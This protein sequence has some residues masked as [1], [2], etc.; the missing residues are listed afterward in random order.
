MQTADAQ[1]EIFTGKGDGTFVTTSTK[2]VFSTTYQA[3][4]VAVGD[5]NG[6]GLPDIAVSSPAQRVAGDPTEVWTALSLTPVTYF[7]NSGL[8]GVTIADF[9]ND[10]KMDILVNEPSTTD[11]S[12]QVDILLGHGDGTFANSVGYPSTSAAT[13]AIVGDFNHDGILDYAV[14]NNSVQGLF[15]TSL[16]S[17]FLGTGDGTFTNSVAQT[18]SIASIDYPQ[19]IAAADFSGSGLLGVA[20]VGLD[21]NVSVNLGYQV[22]SG[23]LPNITVIQ[24]D[25]VTGTYIPGTGDAYAGSTS[26]PLTLEPPS[27]YFS[28]AFDGNAT[29]LDYTTGDTPAPLT[30]IVEQNQERSTTAAFPITLTVQGPTGANAVYHQT[31]VAGSTTFSLPVLT[32]AGTYKVTAHSA[33]AG[34]DATLNLVVAAGAQTAT[35]LFITSP[36][37]SHASKGIA[38]PVTLSVLG[39][40][41]H[42]ADLVHGDCDADDDR[43]RG[44][45]ESCELYVC[46]GGQ[47]RRDLPR[48]VQH[49]GHAGPYI[50]EHGADGG[51]AGGHPCAAAVGD[52]EFLVDTGKLAFPGVATGDGYGWRSTGDARDGELL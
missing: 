49:A 7:C 28:L 33:S 21:T 19:Y 44:A 20:A 34:S 24:E 1:V 32:L 12:G 43:Q 48:D 30:V 2:L 17:F 38:A 11:F 3:Q 47:G 36:Y 23:T 50:F 37:P 13:N 8:R 5:L 46:G 25:T 15:G 16:I 4:Y 26:A 10:G 40:V 35:S 14:G 27:Y 45:G 18:F 31:T 6:D 52:D 41:R 39:P 22:A 9:N 51:Y 42:N 29:E